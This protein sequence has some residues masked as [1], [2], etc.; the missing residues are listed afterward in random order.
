MCLHQADWHEGVIGI[1]ASRIKDKYYRPVIVFASA[2]NG[3][4]KGS[5]RSIPGLHMRDLIDEVASLN[6]GLILRFG[7]HAMAA[8][9]TMLESDLDKFVAEIND[10]VL[11]QLKPDTFRELVFTDGELEAM[12]FDLGCAEQ[13]RTIAPWG[14]WF[15]EPQFEGSFQIVQKRVLLSLIHI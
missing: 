11:R 14:Q 3:Q 5:A 4:V 1:L 12:D 9:L 2:E 10:A 6:P 15:P 13:L 8:G 7:G